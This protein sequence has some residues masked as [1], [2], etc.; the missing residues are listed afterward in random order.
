MYDD[1]SITP[2]NYQLNPTPLRRMR[3]NRLIHLRPQY[4]LSFRFTTLK[5]IL[6]NA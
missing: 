6:V 5:I 3:L 2:P 1:Q 4:Q